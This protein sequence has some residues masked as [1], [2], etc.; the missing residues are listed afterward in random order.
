MSQ[1]EQETPLAKNDH[2]GDLFAGPHAR[3]SDPDTSHEAVASIDISAQAFRILRSYR[4]GRPMLDV[5]AYQLAGFPPHACDGQRCSDLRNAGYIE[6]TGDR[7][8]TPSGKRGYLCKITWSGI[9]YLARRR[10]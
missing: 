3:A 4:N 7:A 10:A 1:D 2:Y 8:I 6:R 5:E 9:A